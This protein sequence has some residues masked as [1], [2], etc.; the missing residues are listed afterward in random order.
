[1]KINQIYEAKE[2]K[3]LNQPDMKFG[4]ADKY[5]QF[6]KIV[7]LKDNGVSAQVVFSYNRHNWNDVTSD[8]GIAWIKENYELSL[9]APPYVYNRLNMIE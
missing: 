2:G 4:L 6:M 8:R 3:R 9:D 5:F 1:M 7:E